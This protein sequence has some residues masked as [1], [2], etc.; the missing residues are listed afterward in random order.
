[1]Y[2][3]YDADRISLCLTFIIINIVTYIYIYYLNLICGKENYKESHV[4]LFYKKFNYTIYNIKILNL[5]I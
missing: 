2:N 3:F 1:M 4:F 5:I